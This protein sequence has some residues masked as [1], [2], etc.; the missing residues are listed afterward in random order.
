[1]HWP[2]GRAGARASTARSR[3]SPPRA[4]CRAAPDPACPALPPA[5]GGARARDR[6]G[7]RRCRV[8]CDS[9]FG[10]GISSGTA[11]LHL[12]LRALGVGPG[13]EVITVPN[14]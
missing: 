1:M 9:A 5:G 13:D 3:R 14:T 4:R 12:G 7:D 6:P 2:H 11:A 8:Y 10:I